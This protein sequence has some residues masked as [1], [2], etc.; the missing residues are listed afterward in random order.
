LSVLPSYY[1]IT[2]SYYYYQSQTTT[3]NQQTN[4]YFNLNQHLDNNSSFHHHNNQM[5]NEHLDLRFRGRPFLIASEL[6]LTIFSFS[7]CLCIADNLKTEDVLMIE[8]EQSK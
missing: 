6:D 4:I 7:C 3:N 5:N 8:K 1:I 2:E